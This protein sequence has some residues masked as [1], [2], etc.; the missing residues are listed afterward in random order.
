M[1]EAKWTCNAVDAVLCV[2]LCVACAGVIDV[3]T[4]STL[5]LA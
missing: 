4:H 5:Q 3:L 2:D 1:V